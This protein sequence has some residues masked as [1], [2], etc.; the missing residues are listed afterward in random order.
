MA[1]DFKDAVTENPL[2][3]TVT[4]TGPS[5]S[6]GRTKFDVNAVFKGSAQK[7]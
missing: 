4:L 7:K 2:F 1:Y 5:I 3:E 6:K